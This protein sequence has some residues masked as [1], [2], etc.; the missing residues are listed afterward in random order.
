[1]DPT[2]TP[3]DHTPASVALDNEEISILQMIIDDDSSMDSTEPM[4]Q[5]EKT[6]PASQGF[7][8]SCFCQGL[9]LSNDTNSETMSEVSKASPRISKPRGRGSKV[10]ELRYGKN[11]LAPGFRKFSRVANT[12]LFRVTFKC[13]LDRYGEPCEHR[14]GIFHTIYDD[15]K[16]MTDGEYLYNGRRLSWGNLIPAIDQKTRGKL[17]QTWRAHFASKHGWDKRCDNLPAECRLM[18]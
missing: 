17:A 14:I 13:G 15:V 10:I 3:A 6:A 2:Q 18:R 4:T 8:P 11:R 7:D 12:D 1:M 16:P 5:G 9:R